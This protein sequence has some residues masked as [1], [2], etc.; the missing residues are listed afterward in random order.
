MAITINTPEPDG[1]FHTVHCDGGLHNWCNDG[2]NLNNGGI[3]SVGYVIRQNQSTVCKA[4]ALLSEGTSNLAEYHALLSALRHCHRLLIRR[5]QV[6][7][8]SQLVQRQVIGRY[9]A[10]ARL[11]PFRQEAQALL[12][13]FASAEVIHVPREENKEADKLAR[14]PGSKGETLP[15][16]H[17]T[18]GR[19][20]ISE[21]QAAMIRWW[22]F[23]KPRP[24]GIKLNTVAARVFYELDKENVSQIIRGQS[25]INAGVKDL[26]IYGLEVGDEDPLASPIRLGSER[27]PEE[28]LHDEPHRQSD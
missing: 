16:D 25:Y 9:K 14:K 2:R 28:P 1:P 20:G 23:H 4:G 6:Y 24:A 15:A 5:V 12:E 26:R 19:R 10:S 13:L 3:M 17:P 8:D 27:T 18:T 11:A 7:M 21:A 22:G